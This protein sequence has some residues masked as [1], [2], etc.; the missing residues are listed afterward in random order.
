M[1]TDLL[2]LYQEKQ[3]KTKKLLNKKSNNI[4]I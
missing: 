2:E 4:D 3:S 1:M